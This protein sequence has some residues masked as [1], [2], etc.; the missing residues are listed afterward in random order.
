MYFIKQKNARKVFLYYKEDKNLCRKSNPKENIINKL[1][2]DFRI[3][4]H[5]NGTLELYMMTLSSKIHAKVA[6]MFG[7]K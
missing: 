5:V 7:F 3:I 4:N 6:I 2:K 1:Y